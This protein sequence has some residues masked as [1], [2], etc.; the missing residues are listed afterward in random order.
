MLERIA[1]FGLGVLTVAVLFVA[2]VVL[3]IPDSGRYFRI[4]S[5]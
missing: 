1:G 5:M 4:K 3:A 2:G